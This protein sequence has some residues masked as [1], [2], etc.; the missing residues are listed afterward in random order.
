MNAAKKIVVENVSVPEVT[1]SC[2]LDYLLGGI[3]LP[4]PETLCHY[5]SGRNIPPS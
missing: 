5:S 3:K 2:L 1:L 4:G